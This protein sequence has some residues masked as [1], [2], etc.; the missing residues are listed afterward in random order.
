MHIMEIDNNGNSIK[1]SYV[2]E[3]GNEEVL[4]ENEDLK[5]YSD[6]GLFRNVLCAFKLELNMNKQLYKNGSI[7]KELYEKVENIILDRMKPWENIIEM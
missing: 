1:D 3:Y 2:D 6:F 5:E 4:Y 7:S